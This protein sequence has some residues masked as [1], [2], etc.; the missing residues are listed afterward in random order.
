MVIRVHGG[1]IDDQMLTGSLRYF[2]ITDANGL[3]TDV[4]GDAGRIAEAAVVGR[5]ASFVA[6]NILTVTGGTSSTAATITVDS[7][8]GSGGILTYSVSE[9][10]V[11]SVLPANTV[12]TTGGAGTGATF[13]LTWSST[14]IVPGAGTNGNEFYVGYNQPVPGSAADQALTEIAKYATITQIGIVSA[15][16]I[17]IACENG[18]FA[19]DQPGGGDAAADM[20]AA[21]VALGTVTVPDNT[22]TGDATFNFAAAT[23]VE[24]TFAL[25]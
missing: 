13:D 22:A 11:Y 2:D 1:I 20:A 4:I 14:I 3:G 12:E 6:T 19:W 25:L 10:G 9:P 7:V 16:V 17:R 21:I 18:G 24:S 23:V 8:D 15:T 5:G